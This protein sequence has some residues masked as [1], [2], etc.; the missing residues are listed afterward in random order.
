MT[1]PPPQSV[2]Q[3]AWVWADD[4]R[5]VD[6]RR[7]AHCPALSQAGVAALEEL[8]ADHD[9]DL[10]SRARRLARE[11]GVRSLVIIRAADIPEKTR[12]FEAVFPPIAPLQVP[13]EPM[14]L[15][16]RHSP[17]ADICN[18]HDLSTRAARSSRGRVIFVGVFLLLLALLQPIFFLAGLILIV[19]AELAQLFQKRRTRWFII[20]GG[21]IV[22]HDR[23]WSSRPE[24]KRFTPPDC[25]LMV[26]PLWRA[27]IWRD[28]S[29]VVTRRLTYLEARALVCAWQSPLTPPCP[30]Q[31]TDLM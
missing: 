25:I 26:R 8:A 13:I 16:E 29:R 1:P 5:R 11:E 21:V 6:W 22:R 18:A 31:W 20:P 3:M 24:L 7:H 9:H 28:R 30:D 23:L 10:V 4:R 15:D 14:E 12:P 17:L 2:C 27:E 19:L